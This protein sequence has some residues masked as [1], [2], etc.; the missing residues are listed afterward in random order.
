MHQLHF[1]LPRYEPVDGDETLKVVTWVFVEK[2]SGL[3]EL[4][5]DGDEGESEGLLSLTLSY[6]LHEEGNKVEGKLLVEL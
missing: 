5:D 3:D 4:S 1:A 2:S 6:L